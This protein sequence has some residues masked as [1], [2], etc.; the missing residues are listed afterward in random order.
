M[1]LSPEHPLVDELV[2]A[3][4]KE[5][6]EDY[7]K[8]ASTKSDFE[9]GEI[10]KDKTGVSLGSFAI[11]PVN[12]K[13]IPIWIADYVLMGYGTGA[14]MAVPGHDERDYE[15]AKKFNLP[16]A[17]V[18][19]GGNIDIEVHTDNQNGIMVNSSNNNDLDL[20]GLQVTEAIEKT[21]N[22]LEDNQ[23]GKRTVQY[24]LRD[25]LFSRQRYWGEPMPIIH[26]KDGEIIPLSE[27]DLPLALP[28]VDK[29]EPTGTGESPL[30][31]IDEWVNTELGRR[32]T[33]TMPQWAGSCWYYLRYTDP[34]NNDE[35]WNKD[36]ESYWMPVDLYVG[37]VEHAVLH[38]LY[39]RFWHHVLYD[40]G[41][42]STKEPF[43]KLFNQGMIG[44]EDGQ[45]MSKS[46]GN[47]V[48]PDDVVNKYGA[49]SFRLYEMFMGPLD[50]SKPWS[51][52]GL[53]GCYRFVQKIWK[54]Y[55][56]DETKIVDKNPSKETTM[57][58]HQTI[59]KVTKDLE[60]LSFNTAVSQM[61]IFVNH[62][63]GQDYYNKDV[64]DSFL[65][66]LN[67]FAPHLSEELNEMISSKDYCPLSEK[68]WPEY[69]N[70]LTISDSIT[71]AVQINGK[72]RGTINVD[73]ST[74]KEDIFNIII[75][76]NKF[77][78]YLDNINIIKK[79]YVPKRL[80][81]FVIS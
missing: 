73:T 61:M 67:P 10:N 47:V 36:K 35:A 11:N 2:T 5:Q 42:V 40:L 51:T 24:K 37:G 26:G 38:L 32:E 71:I 29:Y 56:K 44:G 28:E 43:K 8:S 31:G 57:I 14:I 39:S 25:W 33:N 12:K 20:N 59:K 7:K 60:S 22:W 15:F 62:M 17:E 79:I 3:D 48:N 45:K 77:S 34:L 70:S 16:I 74:K 68:K 50:K 27:S 72:T 46:R 6:V 23:R 19:S 13:M 4:N 52:K 54:L 41:L 76:N 30:A 9:R 65:I 53:Q 63:L 55:T 49:D 21:I 1:V 69:D 75:E 66:I 58:L 81:N 64:L 18:V 80:V 78:K